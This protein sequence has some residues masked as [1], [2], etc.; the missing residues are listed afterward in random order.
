[1][2]VYEKR[3]KVEINIVSLVCDSTAIPR[4]LYA[5]IALPSLSDRIS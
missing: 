3:R 4:G 5:K 1:M 2:L